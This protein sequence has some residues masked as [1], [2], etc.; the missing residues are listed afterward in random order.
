M[1]QNEF[2]FTQHFWSCPI[3]HNC[4]CRGASVGVRKTWSK[5]SCNVNLFG[6]RLFLKSYLGKVHTCFSSHEQLSSY[7][8]CIRITK[9]VFQ[10][11]LNASWIMNF[12]FHAFSP[13]YVKY[14]GISFLCEYFLLVNVNAYFSFLLLTQGRNQYTW[15]HY[16]CSAVWKRAG[17]FGRT[18]QA[19]DSW[20]PSDWRCDHDCCSWSHVVSHALKFGALC[21]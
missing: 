8:G 3:C 16:F 19:S 13:Y 9:W 18:S 6:K 12:S 14:Y 21:I 15:N 10:E 5:T 20:F 17:H 4:N 11:A 7:Q 1:T 2:Q